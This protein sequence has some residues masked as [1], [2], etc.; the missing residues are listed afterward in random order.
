[1]KMRTHIKKVIICFVLIFAVFS[2]FNS[3][4]YGENIKNAFV[5]YT[6][7]YTFKA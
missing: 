3:L 6:K 1:V 7:L 4:S 2:V 5:K